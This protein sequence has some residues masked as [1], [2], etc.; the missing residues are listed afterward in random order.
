MISAVIFDLGGVILKNGV[1]TAIPLY[2]K[3][4]KMP[5]GYLRNLFDGKY[6]IPLEL[7]KIK[8]EDFWKGLSQDLQQ[9]ISDFKTLVFKNF[10]PISETW[11]IAKKCKKNYKLGLLTNNLKEWTDRLERKYNLSK[12]FD[13]IVVSAEVGMRKPDP[14][15]YQLIT[16]KLKIKPTECVFIDDLQENVKGAKKLG[17]KSFQFK[18]SSQCEKELK[19]LGVKI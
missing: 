4:H 13:I 15:I 16:K 7:G 5:K 12:L 6:L 17:I 9:D 19:K 11:K 2:E 10:L 3:K 14:K 18:S 1:Y 8:E